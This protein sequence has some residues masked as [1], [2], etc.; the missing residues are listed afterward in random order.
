MT[1]VHGGVQEKLINLV[2]MKD[3]WVGMLG[4]GRAQSALHQPQPHRGGRVS[5]G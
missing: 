5:G 3:T 1:G 2:E 4:G